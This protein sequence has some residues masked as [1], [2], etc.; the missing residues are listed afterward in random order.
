QKLGQIVQ[1]EIRAITPD[2]VREYA[3]GTLLNGGGGW[4][5]QDSAATPAQWR[6]LS[7]QFQAAALQATPGIPLIWGTDAVH[8]HNNVR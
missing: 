7:E 1:P 4:P 6:A 2:E 5:G 3:I 8:G